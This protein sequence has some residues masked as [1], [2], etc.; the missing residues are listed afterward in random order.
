VKK[1]MLGCLITGL[2]LAAA[3]GGAAYWFIWR[4]NQQAQQAEMNARA[5]APNADGL[6]TKTQVDNYLAVQ[7]A[8][9]AKLGADFERI[10]KKYIEK[11]QQPNAAGGEV[12][13]GDMMAMYQEF[14]ALKNSAKEAKTQSLNAQKISMEEYAW[15]REQVNNSMKVLATGALGDLQ[16]EITVEDLNIP[17]PSGDATSPG[18]EQD[19]TQKLLKEAMGMAN[20]ALKQGSGVGADMSEAQLAAA[21]KNAELLKPHYAVLLKTSFLGFVDGDQSLDFLLKP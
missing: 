11:A 9:F 15:I 6:L 5:F 12:G 3:I 4:P 20:D 7:N 13:V 14:N 2:L 16:K 1:F 17:L 21:K 18:A 19:P 10:K 8:M